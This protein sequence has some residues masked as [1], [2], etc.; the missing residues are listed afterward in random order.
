MV[1]PTKY[2]NRYI[3]RWSILATGP[4]FLNLPHLAAAFYEKK[5]S[6]MLK[7]NVVIRF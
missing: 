6:T 7:M 4:L 3:R 5:I 1:M 2:C